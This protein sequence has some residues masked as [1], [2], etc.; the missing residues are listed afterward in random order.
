ML[1]ARLWAL[2]LVSICFAIFVVVNG[3]IVV[4]DR[5]NHTPQLH[6]VQPL[7]FVL[8]TTGFLPQIFWQPK[9]YRPYFGLC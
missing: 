7:Y 5:A 4:G 3:G 2:A 6:L 8:F 1:L 9:G